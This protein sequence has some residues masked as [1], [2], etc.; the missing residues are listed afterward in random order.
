[1]AEKKASKNVDL[2]EIVTIVGTGKY[3]LIKDAEYKV[4]PIQAEG[5]IKKGAA[6]EKV[7]KK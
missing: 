4:H 3:G 5:L 7:A 2:K 6:T 1:M